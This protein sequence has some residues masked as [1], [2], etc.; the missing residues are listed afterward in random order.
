VRSGVFLQTVPA[1]PGERFYVAARSRTTG[2]GAP[3]LTLAWKKADD[4]WLPAETR[5]LVVAPRLETGAG[6]DWGTFAVAPPGAGLLVVLLGVEGQASP[7]DTL[8]WD[9]VR[10]VRLPAEQQ[11]P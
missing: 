9:D 6:S 7:A 4:A 5:K 3:A 10:V 8:W 11:E 2:K 1:R